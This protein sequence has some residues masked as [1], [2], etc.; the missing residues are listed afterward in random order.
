MLIAILVCF[1]L[2]AIF[3]LI[4]LTYVLQDKETPKA[5]VLLHGGAAALGLL[6]LIIHATQTFESNIA[7][8]SG[9]FVVVALVGFYMVSRDITGK[10]IPKVTAIIHGSVAAIG[11]ILFIIYMGYKI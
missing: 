10:K 2:A 1:L 8:L 3:G 9:L 5:V 4:I 11:V 7:L 6:L